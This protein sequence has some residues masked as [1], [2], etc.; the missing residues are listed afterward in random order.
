[1]HT[2]VMFPY[3]GANISTS[4]DAAAAATTVCGLSL[5]CCVHCSKRFTVICSAAAKCV[6]C[7]YSYC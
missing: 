5:T 1:M 7:Y 2:Y 4:Q 6:C 3:V